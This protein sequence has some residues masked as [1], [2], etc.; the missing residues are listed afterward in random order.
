[1]PIS[2]LPT[3]LELTIDS[4]LENG[5]LASYKIAGNGPRTTIVLQF[6]AN[7]ADTSVSPI[8]Q[9]T[10]LRRKSTNQRRRE[11]GRLEEHENPSTKK[12]M[13]QKFGSNACRDTTMNLQICGDDSALHSQSV[14]DTATC[15]G[16]ETKQTE[17]QPENSPNN[18]LPLRANC[19]NDQRHRDEQQPLDTT[20]RKRTTEE[21]KTRMIT[22]GS[23]K[24]TG[25][26]NIHYDHDTASVSQHSKDT[27]SPFYTHE[28]RTRADSAGSEQKY[29][30][31]P[32]L[33]TSVTLN[34]D[35]SEDESSD[36]TNES[37]H[38]ELDETEKIYQ[39]NIPENESEPNDMQQRI[40]TLSN[41]VLVRIFSM[42][43]D[44]RQRVKQP[45]RNNKFKKIIIDTYR[46]EY[47][48]VAETEDLIVEYCVREKAITNLCAK[49]GEPENQYCKMRKR[50][51]RDWP[52]NTSRIKEEGLLEDVKEFQEQLAEVKHRIA[53]P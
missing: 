19:S 33:S 40:K 29:N 15:T 49:E 42:T 37:Q 12:I 31:K 39:H 43:S 9:S 8:H 10:P 5:K 11:R 41:R 4:I 22:H 28:R 26:S 27:R 1:M 7:M 32:R 36:D 35:H 44:T 14:L 13:Q 47:P 6:D 24:T 51:L 20:T 53:F 18:S 23:N 21:E 2:G 52:D 16:L 38:S 30:H 45:E 50:H 17:A 34:T 25:L 48:I 46:D 3:V